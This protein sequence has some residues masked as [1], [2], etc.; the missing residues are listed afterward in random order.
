MGRYSDRLKKERD[1]GITASS[2][3]RA[4]AS[5]KS[6]AKRYENE[7]N[8]KNDQSS[9]TATA[10]TTDY[11]NNVLN[12]YSNHY[13]SDYMSSYTDRT[14]AQKYAH[15]ADLKNSFLEYLNDM[16][17]RQ[18]KNSG[19]SYD[20][21]SEALNIL[22]KTSDNIKAASD[23]IDSD[24]RYRS[25]FENESDYSFSKKYQDYDYEKAMAAADSLDR[26]AAGAA[27]PNVKDNITKESEWLRDNYPAARKYYDMEKAEDYA[28][29]SVYTGST[30]ALNQNDINNMSDDELKYYWINSDAR[31]RANL[32]FMTGAAQHDITGGKAQQF[33]NSGYDWM[34]DTQKATYNYVYNTQGAAAAGEYLDS[35]NLTEQKGRD[36]LDSVNEFS[37]ENPVLASIASVGLAPLTGIGYL[38]STV[39]AFANADYDPSSLLPEIAKK[40]KDNV[41]SADGGFAD[42]VV[43]G[44]MDS[45]PDS[46]DPY[47]VYNMPSRIQSEIRDT[48]NDNIDNSFGKF[49][50]GTGMSMADMGMN[51]LITGGLNPGASAG[52]VAA[53]EAASLG[54]MGTGAA[55]QTL[56]SA[57]DK[58]MSQSDSI[59]LATVAGAAEILTE[60]VSLDALLEGKMEKSGIQYLMKNMLTEGSEEVASDVID[61]AADI[62]ISKDKSDWQM[63]ID[64]YMAQG[65]S[66]SQAFGKAVGD[67]ALQM[68]QDFAGGAVSGGAFAGG[69]LAVNGLNTSI[70][71]AEYA[72]S[73]GQ[74]YINNPDSLDELINMAK[75]T[76]SKE[77]TKLAEKIESSSYM[78]AEQVGRLYMSVSASNQDSV[79]KDIE[80][81][82]KNAG[83]GK[84]NTAVYTQIARDIISDTAGDFELEKV[85]NNSKVSEIFNRMLVDPMSYDMQDTTAKSGVEDAHSGTELNENNNVVGSANNDNNV[86]TGQNTGSNVKE[87]NDNITPQVDDITSAVVNSTGKKVDILRY[88]ST[89]GG[90]KYATSDNETVSADSVKLSDA[91]NVL[92]SYAGRYTTAT[93]NKMLYA[94]KAT[95]GAEYSDSANLFGKVWD[96]MYVYG[97]TNAYSYADA[98]NT[99]ID[100]AMPEEFYKMAFDS[101]RADKA[102]EVAKKQ[103]KVDNLKKNVEKDGKNLSVSGIDKKTAD[104]YGVSTVSRNELNTRQ[105]EAADVLDVISK[106]LGIHVYLFQDKENSK[107]GKI[108]GFQSGNNIYLNIN[109]GGIHEQAVLRTAAHE[110]THY[111]QE[112]SPK[113]YE[114]LKGYVTGK[115]YESGRDTFAS[116]VKDKMD[117]LNLEREAA[118]DEVI[119]DAC[120]MM[121]KDGSAVQELA[122]EHKS[123]WQHIKDFISD[124]IK[125]LTHAME[126]IDEASPAAVKLK[127]IVG[128]WTE[129]QKLW[130]KALTESNMPIYNKK[131][132]RFS[133]NI[134]SDDV[135]ITS[136][137]IDE[138]I[139]NEFNNSINPEL[140]LY[141]ED[142][143][144][145]IGAKRKYLSRVNERASKKILDILGRDVSG[146]V[147]VI[148]RNAVNHIIIRHGLE[149]KAN[150]SMADMDNVARIEY[151]LGN[152]D[153]IYVLLDKNGNQ[154]YSKQYKDSGNKLAPKILFTKK[155]GNKFYNITVAA[156]INNSNSVG[157]VTASL[158]S[159]IP[160][161]IK[162]DAQVLA[163]NNAH[164]RT[165][166]T[167][168]D[169]SSNSNISSIN[170]EINY[171]SSTKSLNNKVKFSMDKTYQNKLQQWYD[172]TTAEER[173]KSLGRFHIG[174]TSDALQ[175]IGVPDYNI[176]IGKSKIQKI[177]D[178]HPEM[179]IEIFK[180]IPALIENPVIVLESHTRPGDSLIV[181]G[182]VYTSDNIPVMAAI[183]I[184]PTNKDGNLEEFEIV[185]SSYSR[186]IKQYQNFL[187]NDVIKY[188]NPDKNRTNSWLSA[189]GLQLPSSITNYGSIDNVTPAPIK[190]NTNSSINNDTKYSEA[191][192]SLSTR[193]VLANTLM[194][195]ATGEEAAK[196]ATYKKAIKELDEKEERLKKTKAMIKDMVFSGN[197]E[198]EYQDKKVSLDNLN[199]NI[200]TLEG[201]INYWDRQLLSLEATKP[202]KALA[203]RERDALVKKFDAK[204]RRL[205]KEERTNTKNGML[206]TRF[207][208]NIKSKSK[209]MMEWIR[210]PD[211]KHHV[212]EIIERPVAEFLSEIDFL[213]A[214]SQPDSSTTKG[215]YERLEAVKSALADMNSMEN[216]NGENAVFLNELDPDLLPSLT[217]FI[218]EH[219]KEEGRAVHISE[220]DT[221]ELKEL[222]EI[223]TALHAAINNINKMYGNKLSEDVA[224]IGKRTLIDLSAK[225]E[226]FGVYKNSKYGQMNNNIAKGTAFALNTSDGFFNI[227]MLD[228]YSYFNLM[229]EGGHSIYKELREGLNTRT[230]CI[231]QAQDKM[232]TDI[233]KDINEKE[234]RKWVK[235]SH[236]FKLPGDKTLRMTQTQI[237]D[238]Y[239]LSKRQQAMGH[240]SKGGIKL[241]NS[242]E[243]LNSMVTPVH[244]PE[245]VLNEILG[246]LSEQQKQICDKMQ[247]YLSTEV[248]GWGNEV[249]MKM[250]GYRKFT[251]KF[252]WPIKTDSN[253]NSTSDKTTVTA[254]L[255]RIRNQGITKATVDNANNAIIVRDIFD[256]FTQHIVDMANYSGYAI[257]LTDA[258]KWFNYNEKTEMDNDTIKFDSVKEQI[259]RAYGTKAQSYFTKLVL[260]LNGSSTKADSAIDQATSKLVSNW[261]AAAVGGNLRVAI[262]QP[263]AY[264]RAAAVMDAKYLIKAFGMKPGIN[265]CLKYSRIAQWKS[266]GYFETNIGKSMKNIITGLNESIK[267]AVVDKTMFLAQKADDITWGC[268]WNAV[269]AEQHDAHPDMDVKSEK[270]M[271]LVEERF[272]EVIDRTQV[273]DTVLH[274]SH[275]MRSKSGLNQIATSFMAEPTKT[276]NLTRNAWVQFISNRSSRTIKNLG[277][278][279]GVVILTAAVNAMAQSISDAL[280]SADDED[281]KDKEYWER[282]IDSLKGN[283]VDNVNPIQFL[284]YVKDV[285]SMVLGYT[286]KRSDTEGIYSV[287]MAV[288][289]LDKLINDPNYRKTPA[290]VVM[291][292]AKAFSQTSGIPLYNAM[293]DA[294]SIWDSVADEPIYLE[295]ETTG[296]KAGKVMELYEKGDSGASDKLQELLSEYETS[297]KAQYPEYTEDKVRQQAKSKLKSNITSAY[298]EDYVSGSA[299][300]KNEIVNAM[301]KTKLYESRDDILKTV[302]G[303]DVSYWK[304]KYLTAADS[305]DRK[306]ARKK[307]YATGKWESLIEL[308]KDI[309]KWT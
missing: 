299:E 102:A 177:L 125:K 2:S 149:G 298:K 172:S 215:W 192:A 141:I 173:L 47:D 234:I 280:R 26:T 27:N 218:Y 133:E 221:A 219:Q 266:F 40:Y 93:A 305:N 263:T 105:A 49:A 292:C 7:K 35:L 246:T 6:Y 43:S 255:Y 84:K 183:K 235:N 278:T 72:K 282:Y 251:E 202:L 226:K 189:L 38:G 101:G 217:N 296:K 257:P 253:S 109:A 30:D 123:L 271:K 108:H 167:G 155:I 245:S 222:S 71:N 240:I 122:A 265:D 34:S 223:V 170:E 118:V 303:W 69:G 196:L 184:Y 54:L 70:N 147:Y 191:A 244:I 10:L 112:A 197:S 286:I 164:M 230:G 290:Y 249:S 9:M 78:D 156:S 95:S 297:I 193:E 11:S 185:S 41:A 17:S 264:V 291:S 259:E 175:S 12:D 91:M 187:D 168:L 18:V 256:V 51:L 29:N 37:D 203:Q 154:L 19:Y 87:Y 8:K 258:M 279:V 205:L 293:R 213:S 126:G 80:T 169:I 143:I 92:N 163:S 212:P 157:I 44:V 22:N 159:V 129:L 308:D 61:L 201:S 77:T 140:K 94:Y 25:Q 231:V 45:N 20:D 137:I 182:E 121:L 270:Y 160:N 207:R 110:L 85:K 252:Y 273:V 262:Q 98:K 144:N 300:R 99:V 124:I 224:V 232:K 116:L 225:K 46:V 275:I 79:V 59:K 138:K 136:E 153:D 131:G 14:D 50:Y 180:E 199:K 247:Q 58:G 294:K 268:L 100:D 107:T 209:D 76:G 171:N 13:S 16:S 130:N 158:D 52:P 206:N 250:Y 23:Y 194:Q 295:K 75:K 115:Y 81:E 74:N 261:K 272:D 132:A 24:Y 150:K 309:K 127:G 306:E 274:R 243:V 186:P 117:A 238:L 179:N 67:Q 21:K 233:L 165:S 63:S 39:S 277:R 5:T 200:K 214:R 204:N 190:S 210:K 229:G 113:M 254:S 36:V 1:E 66:K 42:A 56:N 106:A 83:F 281:E 4:E 302:M 111:I 128:E 104:K 48:V 241:Q 289:S 176:Y 220:L 285:L 227:D 198:M 119:A 216:D 304:N 86:L 307:L 237:M 15:D 62:I 211:D 208:D 284:P 73:V 145:G 166:E 90:I 53:S 239:V 161:N 181:L 178:K 3:P 97:H 114:E 162:E 32:G 120:E 64:S 148:D 60:K 288:K 89:D 276:Y 242:D 88:E 269:K 236:E 195:S 283:F 267:D 152:F 142:V 31:N 28:A 65:Y 139:I 55:S 57:M 188:I 33:V 228:S 82:L 103:L 301:E 96:S 146:E 260:D 68:A 151:V 287:I 134:D 135:K 248:S 174:Y